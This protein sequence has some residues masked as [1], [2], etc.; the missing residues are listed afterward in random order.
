[1]SQSRR[2]DVNG[3]CVTFS[4]RSGFSPGRWP[5]LARHFIETKRRLDPKAITQPPEAL[6][7]TDAGNLP[8]GEATPRACTGFRKRGPRSQPDARAPRVDGR[9][10]TDRCARAS[11][12]PSRGGRAGA[13]HESQ[14]LSPG[15]PVAA[16]PGPPTHQPDLVEA[17]QP[18]PTQGP[19]QDVQLGRHVDRAGSRVVW[20][21]RSARPGPGSRTP[22][23]LEPAPSA[24]GSLPSRCARP[25]RRPC[26][27][28]S[29]RAPGRGDPLR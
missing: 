24:A 21:G 14:L 6:R 3:S 19:A 22:R 9:P 13:R 11:A 28:R 12:A 29:H 10:P 18:A 5:P 17:A 7:P 27:A 15:E 4:H 20:R 1:M 2:V 16:L 8:T 25:A 23:R 26:A